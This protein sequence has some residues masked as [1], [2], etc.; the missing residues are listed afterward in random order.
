MSPPTMFF[1]TRHAFTAFILVVMALSGTG[2]AQRIKAEVL[3]VSSPEHRVTGQTCIVLP[4]PGM[5]GM[6]KATFEQAA[7]RVRAA[8]SG[9]GYRPVATEDAADMGVMLSW[10]SHGPYQS[11]VPAPLDPRP[12][13]SP[14]GWARQ[15]SGAYGYGGFG[16][17]FG[18]VGVGYGDGWSIK[19]EYQREL[20]IEARMRAQDKPRHMDA[21]GDAQRDATATQTPEKGG[22][23]QADAGASSGPAVG[24][25]PEYARPPFAPPLPA[26][27]P[28]P[29][30]TFAG[31]RTASRAPLGQVPPTG[32]EV[33]PFDGEVAWRVVVTSDGQRPDVVPILPQLITAA[34]RWM[35]MTTSTRVTIDD[36]LTVTP[37]GQ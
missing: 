13:S 12:I 28:S 10:A 32:Q 26:P 17:G 30:G 6:D 16:R 4:G 8:L 9:K 18:G 37:R 21:T 24:D 29:A 14:F 34:T 15:M 3:S 23:A 7:G 36:E 2:C 27:S 31:A 20:V 1:S 22:N 25:L 35:G 5:T 11:R 33:S 19:S